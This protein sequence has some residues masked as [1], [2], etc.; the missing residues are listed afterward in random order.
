MTLCMILSVITFIDSHVINVDD[1]SKWTSLTHF[2]IAKAY[3][4][5]NQKY[6]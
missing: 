5:S 2:N 3:P 1:S 4:Y 6:E